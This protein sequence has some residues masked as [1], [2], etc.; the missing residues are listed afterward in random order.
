MKNKTIQLEEEI[1]KLEE[2]VNLL[3][4]GEAN[5]DEMLVKYE[6]GVKIIKECRDYLSNAELKVIEIG[7][8]IIN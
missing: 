1:K 4:D 6:A 7:K 3:E 8:G 5:I 2:I